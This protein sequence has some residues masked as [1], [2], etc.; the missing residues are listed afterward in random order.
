MSQYWLCR[1]R[2]INLDR[3]LVMGIL[4]VT[5]DSFSENGVNFKVEDA[6]ANGLQML[7]DGADV[8]DVG[9]ESTRPGATP[10]SVEEEIRRVVPVIEAL[11]KAAPEA[12][13][14]VDTWKSEVGAAAMAAGA[15]IINDVTG[16][17]RDPKLANVAVSFQAG[18]VLMHMRGTPQTMQNPENLIYQDL[19]PE[20]NDF[21]VKQAAALEA[22]GLARAA[23]MLDPGLGFSKNF[24]QNGVIVR[25]FDQFLTPGYP[26]LLAP[27][28]KSFIGQI[29]DEPVAAKRD[30]GTAA[31]ITAAVL[32][33]AAMVRIH[34]VKE[35]AQ[36]VKVAQALR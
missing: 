8:L 26:V 30:W 6:V 32:K 36:V 12:L 24:A 2:K 34:A 21:M 16:F 22:M 3:C 27:S 23:I 17:A 1:G 33:G 7:A 29:L 19:I 28:R 9:G 13:I 25:D 14:S 4:N 10:V 31:V 15:D 35:M 5:P 18:V 11:R 20:I